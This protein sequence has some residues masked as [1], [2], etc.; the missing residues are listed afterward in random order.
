MLER[1]IAVPLLLQAARGWYSMLIGVIS[2]THDNL[3]AARRAARLF[4][5]R[6]V[7]L[8]LHLGDIVAPF[9]LRAL[10]ENGVKN[11]VAVYGNNCGEKLGLREVASKLGYEIHEWP[12]LVEVDHKRILMIHGIGPVEKTRMLV[13]SLAKSRDYDVVLY[14]HT[15]V[16][17][18]RVIGNTL[19]LN[20]G[21][22]CGC[23]SGRR[24]VAILD[25][26][27]LRAEIIEI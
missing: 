18:N 13:D 7:D 4:S 20:P 27:E 11:L 24:T 14:G 26:E 25:T 22:A 8:V 12:H 17:D 23:L 5:T 9:T 21:E 1:I 16:V 19:V 6:G 2:D 3:E 15:H 10:R